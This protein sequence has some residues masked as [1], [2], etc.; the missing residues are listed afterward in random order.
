MANITVNTADIHGL[1]PIHYAILNSHRKFVELLLTSPEW[2]AII[3]VTNSQH[4][5]NELAAYIDVNTSVSGGQV[6]LHLA[7]IRGR[8]KNR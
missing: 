2:T 3:P 4:W 6:L 8:E 7:S 5:L 1:T